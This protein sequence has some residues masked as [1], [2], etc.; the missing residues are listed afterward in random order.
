MTARISSGD[1]LVATDIT[2]AYADRVVLDD[3]SLTAAPG[4]RIGLVGDNGSGK[5]TLLRL[6]AGIEVPDAGSVRR[7]EH[8]ALLEQDLAHPPATTI[9]AVIEAALAELRLLAQTVQELSGLVQRM[10]DDV[11]LAREYGDAL[12]LAQLRQVWDADHRVARVMRGL[13]LEAFERT[14]A[15]GTLSGG[16]RARVAMAALLVRQPEAL[17]LDEP[18]NHLDD[19][20][21]AFV[22]RH[23]R[24]LPG[25]V[26]VSSHDRAFLD[27]VCTDIVDIDPARDGVTRFGGSF[28]DYLEAKRRARQAW[29][30]AF[31]DQ[32]REL[33]TLGDSV[34]DQGAA[35]QVAVGRG[36]RD[37]DKFIHAFKGAR[38]QKTVARR[39]KDARGRIEQLER[40]A[41]AEPP[42]QLRFGAVIGA[43]V[44]AEEALLRAQEVTHDGR[45]SPTT[46]ELRPGARL[47]ITG[48]NGA[49]KS[50]L[51][52]LLAGELSPTSGIVERLDGIRVGVLHQD[53]TF[54]SAATPRRLYAAAARD[55]GTAAGDLLDLGLLREDDL[56][57]PMGELSEGQR[58]RVA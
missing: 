29:E 49:G 1:A 40:D 31:A 27:A 7:P 42:L 19:A 35:R 46:L 30:R 26:V 48:P 6:L 9:H 11:Q 28:S 38:V 45:V 16:E 37:N 3:V 32:Q 53:T 17:L 20:G 33:R 58:R 2:H 34:D 13:G 43:S 23:L 25:V 51:L 21:L 5:S 22:E 10:P 57:R 36:P 41:I 52:Q 50:T 18:T 12:E 4:R 55:Y 15:I 39:V 47:L 44:D 24:G 8:T 54:P 14:R 56:D